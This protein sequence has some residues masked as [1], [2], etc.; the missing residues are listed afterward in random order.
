MSLTE[1]LLLITCINLTL[2]VIIEIIK[3]KKDENNY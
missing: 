1:I 3:P 2:I